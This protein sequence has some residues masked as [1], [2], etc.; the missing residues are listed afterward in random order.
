MN[1]FTPRLYTWLICAVI[2][3]LTLLVAA[4]GSGGSQIAGGVGSGGTGVAEGAVSGFGS[5]IVA[6][7]EYDDTNA[8]AVIENVDGATEVTEVKLGQRVRIRHSKAGVADTI[9]VL[10]QL[11]GTATSTQ[12]STLGGQVVFQ[13]LGQTVRIIAAGDMQNTATVLAGLSTVAAGDALEV[14]GSWVLDSTR[15]YSVL[16]ATR[17]EKLT[18]APDLVLISGVV[19]SRNND[20]LITLDDAA[21]HTLQYAN[22]PASLGPQSAITAWVTRS[23]LGNTPWQAQRV[24][25]ASPSLSDNEHLMLNT[26]VSTRDA[27][28]G[29][30][31]VQGMRVKLPSSLSSSALTA[32]A[33][34]QIEIVREGS[35]FKAV[36]LTQRQIASDLGGVV[37]LKGSLLWSAN[38]TQLTLRGN[39]VSLPQGALAS[40]CRNLNAN[41]Q[42]YLE[43]KAQPS[44]PGQPLQATSV[45]CSLQTPANSVREASGVL[46]RLSPTT[47]QIE[48]PTGTLSLVWSNT[49]LRPPNLG[50]LLNR[51]VEV[52]YQTVNGEN[53]LRKISLD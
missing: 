15:G 19:R 17:I 14:H 16:I 33:N 49:S 2:A 40:D 23:T 37:E 32:G 39:S 21:G 52:E 4:C 11:R 6:G 48:T 47:M 34:V 25:D 42:V 27:E 12:S 18:T 41:D 28:Q 45:S 10:P 44:T 30:I 38:Q 13:I 22:L 9:Q 8:S 5:V 50:N 43:I 3:L 51:T 7:V 1:T 35:A 24:V 20:V 26:Q 29:D 53:R 36:A 46:T 31:V